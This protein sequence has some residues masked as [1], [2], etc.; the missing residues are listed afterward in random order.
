MLLI[1]SLF[2]ACKEVSSSDVSTSEIFATISG[3]SEFNTTEIKVNLNLEKEDSNTYVELAYGDTLCV[4]DGTETTELTHSSF[5][6]MHS[7]YATLSQSASGSQ[8]V[9]ELERSSG[10]SAPSSV[11]TLP[12]RFEII[13]PSWDDVVYLDQPF[14]ISWSI[15]D[16]VV[17]EM[18]IEIFSTCLYLDISETV[19][20]QAGF[21][22]I[23]PSDWSLE[24]DIE[25]ETCSADIRLT[26]NQQGTLDP[27]FDGGN[28]YGSFTEEITID[29]VP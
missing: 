13:S 11:I 22:T 28:V 21:L 24:D 1:L 17:D 14:V 10:D 26:R 23:N 3:V 5:A 19:G 4:Q 27:A 7:Y 20:T 12:N 2:V 16:D 8:F 29:L 25:D 6:G 15:D 18:E 9:V